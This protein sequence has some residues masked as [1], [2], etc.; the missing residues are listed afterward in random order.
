MKHIYNPMG[1]LLITL[2]MLLGW[3]SKSQNR[4]ETIA[5]KDNPYKVEKIKFKNDQGETVGI[6]DIEAN[7]PF[8][9]QVQAANAPAGSNASGR[10]TSQEIRVKDL[11][12]NLENYLE[13]N[14]GDAIVE[15][16][17]NK[18]KMIKNEKNEVCG[19]VYTLVL[20]DQEGVVGLDSRILKVNSQGNVTQTITLKHDARSA[21]IFEEGRIIGV[22]KGGIIDHDGHKFFKEGFV[23]IDLNSGKEL[24]ELPSDNQTVA[25]TKTHIYKGLILVEFDRSDGVKYVA[26][27]PIKRIVYIKELTLS[28][29]QNLVDL[30][31]NGLIFNFPSGKARLEFKETFTSIN[32]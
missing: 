6:F 21:V 31:K 2:L 11:V 10:T 12:G 30:D 13:K 17:R 5:K 4:T 8:A 28:E 3:Q 16:A 24:L 18:L 25:I 15:K 7:N 20:S 14:D 32:Y 1:F 22:V 19:L 26:V 23:L 9:K 29:R 27:D